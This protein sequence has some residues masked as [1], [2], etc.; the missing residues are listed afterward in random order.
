MICPIDPKQ[1]SARLRSFKTTP[2]LTSIKANHRIIPLS[3]R[4][5]I[6][7]DLTN[8]QKTIAIKNL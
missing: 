7:L 8:Y 6:I 1:N 3:F 5:I 2:R 4:S